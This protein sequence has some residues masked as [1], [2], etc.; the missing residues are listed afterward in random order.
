MQIPRSEW[1]KY[2]T[3]LR[4]INDKA[5]DEL[6]AYLQQRGGFEAVDRNELID[7]SYYLANKYGEASAALSAEMYDT[8]AELSRAGVPAAIPA[9]TAT[10]SDVAKTVNGIIKNT[11]SDSVL[12]QGIGRL[13][14][15]AGTDTMLS[16]AYRDR[17]KSKGSKKKHSGAQVAWVP[18]GDTCPFCITLASKGWQYQTE[19]GANSHSE[20][21]HANCDCTYMVRFND[22]LNVEGYDPEKYRE[23][24]LEAGD[25]RDDR[26][27]AMRREQ[28]QQD[29]DKIN[30]QKRAAYAERTEKNVET[31]PGFQDKNGEE[32]TGRWLVDNFGGH[33]KLLPENN[34][35][36]MS[37]PDY[38]WNGKYWELK[39]PK[40]LNGV[41]KRL[42]HGLEQIRTNPGGIVIDIEKTEAE[43]K[44]IEKVIDDRLR[45]SAKSDVDVILKKGD[46]L[47]KEIHHKK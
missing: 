44:D 38:L 45:V 36:G 23:E 24:Y 43:I 16:N 17:P 11:G 14:K 34:P 12:A 37:N 4:R 15:M 20:H 9:E 26:I 31:V 8:V 2:I 22:D 3:D 10:Y 40:S 6:T 32:K 25:N 27:N 13:V 29:K 28:Y 39:S 5:V 35:E 7:Y 33:I 18:S 1:N 41:S 46:E 42:K 30:A 47:I 19:W 21:I